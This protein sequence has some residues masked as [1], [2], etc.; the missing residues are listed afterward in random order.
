M[1]HVTDYNTFEKAWLDYLA[2]YNETADQLECRSL[3]CSIKDYAPCTFEQFLAQLKRSV[4]LSTKKLSMP[5]LMELA[6]FDGR[7]KEQA[8]AVALKY[9]RILIC[10]QSESLDYCFADRRACIAFYLTFG[11]IR[12]FLEMP[13]KDK[14][15]NLLCRKFIDSYLNC[16]INDNM[17]ILNNFTFYHGWQD[18]KPKKVVPIGENRDVAILCD[19]LYGKGKWGLWRNELYQRHIEDFKNIAILCMPDP[20]LTHKNQVD[21]MQQMIGELEHNNFVLENRAQQINKT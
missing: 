20:Q 10:N 16:S 6:S 1:F 5:E 14:N 11:T 13:D 15:E 12:Q 3:F 4:I 8:K 21:L 17:E 19:Q 7:N 9:F 2:V 18:Q